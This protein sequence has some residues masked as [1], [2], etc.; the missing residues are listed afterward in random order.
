MNKKKR[1]V[2]VLVS[3]K[4]KNSVKSAVKFINNFE[5]T[6]A[7]IGITGYFDYVICALYT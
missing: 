6:S 1:P 2:D 3:E 7:D 4:I 5:E